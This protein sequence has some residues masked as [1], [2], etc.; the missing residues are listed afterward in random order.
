MY[1]HSRWAHCTGVPQQSVWNGL[2]RPQW[3]AL[4][5]DRLPRLAPG[6]E[7][8]ARLRALAALGALLQLHQ[9][10]PSAREDG[11]EGGLG[12]AAAKRKLPVRGPLCLPAARF[13]CWGSW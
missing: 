10:P 5:L 7:G 2:G 12:A 8:G 3:P 11:P 9:G 6:S 13:V 4:V 1:M